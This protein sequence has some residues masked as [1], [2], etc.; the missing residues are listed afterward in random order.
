MTRDGFTCKQ[1]GNCCSSFY[2]GETE[3]DWENVINFIKEEHGEILEIIDLKGKPHHHKINS[4]DDIPWVALDE[5]L[6]PF[7]KRLKDKKDKFTSKFYCEIHDFK[8]KDCVNFPMDKEHA[9]DYC[10]CPGY[11]K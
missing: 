6:C 1:C 11:N 4:K 9:L 10:D 2:L 8:P 3:V 5:C 7:L